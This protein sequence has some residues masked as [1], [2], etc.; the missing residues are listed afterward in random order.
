MQR[1]KAWSAKCIAAASAGATVV[2][3][4]AAR[5][6]TGWWQNLASVAIQVRFVKGRLAFVSPTGAPASGAGFPSSVVVLAPNLAQYNARE[7][8]GHGSPL[9]FLWDVPAEIRR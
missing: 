6:D 9:M 8:D 7:E 5:T 2:V 1:E 3:L 4:C